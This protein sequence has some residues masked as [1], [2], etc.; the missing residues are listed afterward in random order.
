[1]KSGWAGIVSFSLSLFVLAVLVMGP[2]SSDPLS[3]WQLSL[4]STK[5]LRASIEFLLAQGD[6]TFESGKKEYDQGK[7]MLAAGIFQ[8]TAASDPRSAAQLGYMYNVASYFDQDNVLSCKLN[9]LA[10]DRYDNIAVL[11]WW[12]TCGKNYA[13]EQEKKSFVLHQLEQTSAGSALFVLDDYLITSGV[14]RDGYG[15]LGGF[16]AK[17]ID[18]VNESGATENSSEW[19]LEVA[20]DYFFGINVPQ[21]YLRSY[22]WFSLLKSYKYSVSATPIPYAA[23]LDA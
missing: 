5:S 15:H 18:V 17:P 6:P 14:T 16:G 19:F 11:N 7:L 20:F 1:M 10:A 4:K 21:S 9:R 22:M 13:T 8:R 23:R 2:P 12:S 3:F